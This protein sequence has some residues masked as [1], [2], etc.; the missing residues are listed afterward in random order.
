[1]SVQEIRKSLWNAYAEGRSQR[2]YDELI[3]SYLPL[4]R[5]IVS[6]LNFKLPNHLEQED[7]VSYGIFGL[8]EAI[9]KFDYTR[10]VKFETYASQRI[11]G[12]IVD[13][14]RREQWAPRSVADKLKELQRAYQKFENAGIV[15]VT[16]TQLAEEMG[17]SIKELRDIMAEICQLSVV[18]L[19]EFLH[20]HDMENICRVDTLSDP[21]SP[22]PIANIL[23]DE[24]KDY[25]SAAIDELPEK[26]RV[27]ISLYYYEEL[28]LREIGKVLEVSESRVSQLH[29]RALMRLRENLNKY[30]GTKASEE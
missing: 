3:Y 21:S 18:S 13:A 9:K 22:N 29:A 15:D 26:D 8:M 10:G 1:M 19:D 27:V 24:F 4:V 30:M 5:F 25:L 12:A 14:L 16:E 17:I 23:E 6:R 28:T 11:R 7:L 20:G 2:A